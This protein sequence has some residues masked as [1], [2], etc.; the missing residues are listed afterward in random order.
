VPSL[1]P[2]CPKKIQKKA[3]KKHQKHTALTRPGFGTFNRQE[4]TILGTNCGNIQKLSSAII[5]T[6]SPKYNLGYVDADH[7][8]V[9]ENTESTIENALNKGAG[10]EYIDKIDFHRFDTKNDFN[11]FQYREWFNEQDAVL[12]NGN[13][14]KG[15]SQIVV[16]D[17][18]KKESL[19]RKLDR[20]TNV[21][22]FL[23]AEGET[24]V[25]DFLKTHIENW[26]NLPTL[27]LSQEKEIANWIEVQIHAN[28]APL[29]GLVLAG[30]KS[31]RMG[32]DKA[33][34]DYHGIPQTAY[35][36]NLLNGFC[37]E[38]YL[39]CREDQVDHFQN[40]KVIKDTFTGLGPFGAILSAFREN[41]NAAWLV[42]AVDLPLADE[43][44]LKELIANR[45]I[46]KNATAFLNPATGFPDPLITIWEPRSYATLLQYLAQGYSCPRKTLI[47]S[48]IELIET[49]QADKLKNVNSPE[50]FSEVQ[51]LLKNYKK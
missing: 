42:M 30:G 20:L 35:A 7:K 17:Q 43:A 51:A 22:L 4:W 41:P 11:E 47:N 1:W 9:D 44:F 16:I 24:E 45:N 29:N 37:K 2:L 21:Q 40:Y 31:Q 48:N 38:V 13:H 27:N 23:F 12:I 6:L 50:E 18:K 39:S 28:I 14:F 15:K 8:S 36:T 3:M 46:S 19:Y 33:T 25:Y 26:E 10:L 32:K 5:E 34:L 49:T